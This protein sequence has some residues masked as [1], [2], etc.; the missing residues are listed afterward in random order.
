MQPLHPTPHQTTLPLPLPH[1]PAHLLLRRLLRRSPPRAPALLCR[2]L[3]AACRRGEGALLPGPQHCPRRRR[4]P[5][6]RRLGCCCC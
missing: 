3:L 5:R 2:L 1:C 6:S 4:Q